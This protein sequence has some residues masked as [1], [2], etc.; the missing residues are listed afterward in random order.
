MLPQTWNRF[1]MTFINKTVIRGRAFFTAPSH[2]PL[3]YAGKKRDRLSHRGGPTPPEKEGAK[4]LM[5]EGNLLAATVFILAGV[6]AREQRC[7]CVRVP[8][9]KYQS[10]GI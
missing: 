3:K 1:T 5:S 2:S 4:P 6:S 8:A 10:V 7:H 9:L